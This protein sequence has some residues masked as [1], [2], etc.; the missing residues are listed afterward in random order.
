MSECPNIC[1]GDREFCLRAPEIS[2]NARKF[3]PDVPGFNSGAAEI[4]LGAAGFE[5]IRAEVH[6]LLALLMFRTE[7][8]VSACVPTKSRQPHPT[9]PGG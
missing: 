1:P 6:R 4:L 3:C 5:V 7:W 9:S 2:L 8:L